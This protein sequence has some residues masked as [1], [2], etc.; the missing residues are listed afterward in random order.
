M[1]T[2]PPGRFAKGDAGAGERS[3]D[4]KKSIPTESRGD[5]GLEQTECRDTQ[6][7][8]IAAKSLAEPPKAC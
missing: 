7:S 8:C 6:I 1:T 3:N 4:L 5:V 2:E